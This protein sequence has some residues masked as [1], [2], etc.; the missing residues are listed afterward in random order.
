MKKITTRRFS[1]REEDAI[2]V[3]NI[4][5]F[6][7]MRKY[8]KEKNTSENQI[9]VRLNSDLMKAEVIYHDDAEKAAIDDYVDIENDFIKFDDDRNTYYYDVDAFNDGLKYSIR[10]SD[11]IFDNF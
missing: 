9:S 2:K 7:L 3:R 11:V 6:S 4:I 1:G 10:F 5:Y 8:A